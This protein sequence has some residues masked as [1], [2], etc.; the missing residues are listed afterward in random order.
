[1][2]IIESTFLVG[3]NTEEAERRGHCKAL[4]EGRLGIKRVPM[5][6]QQ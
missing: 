6:G 2:G 4:M 5:K 1:M 3:V